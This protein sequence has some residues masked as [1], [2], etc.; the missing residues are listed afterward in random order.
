ML[1]LYDETLPTGAKLRRLPEAEEAL[2]LKDSIS[3]IPLHKLLVLRE[4]IDG[5]ARERVRNHLRLAL[6]TVAVCDASNLH[7]GPEVGLGDIRNDAPV[8][9]SW[10]N[11]VYAM[12]TDLRSLP[13]ARPPVR[14]HRADARLLEEVL[15]SRSVDVVITSPPYPNEKDYTRTTRLET[16]LLGFIRNRADLRDLKRGLIRSNTRNVYQGDDDEAWVAP[17]ESIQRIAREIETR[18]LALG[19]TSGFERLYHRVTK[20]YFG[21]LAR[22]LAGLR[23]ILKPGA[24]L[25]YVVGDQASYL[26]VM[27]R[28][29]QLLAEIAD[30]LG[31][32]V[33]GLDLFRT[34]LATATRE[35]LRE[36]VLRLRWPGTAPK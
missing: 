4:Q 17:F 25:A 36:E 18:R 10:L 19:K 3:P 15:E 2:L 28:T 33:E 32:Q 21:G 13:T 9:E 31:Y 12:A 22:H 20:H 26:R 5:I 6:A 14:I 24:R 35:T 23:R 1:P 8:V 7:F 16:V 11:R 34:R 30:H 29:G 27:I